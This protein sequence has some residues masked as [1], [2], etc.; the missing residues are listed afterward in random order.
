MIIRDK[1]WEAHM[2][3]PMA[4]PDGSM[5]FDW[6]FFVIVAMP[7]VFAAWELY[8]SYKVPRQD[9]PRYLKK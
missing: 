8:K 7:M 3:T 6:I 4:K 1:I 2:F 5:T 9:G